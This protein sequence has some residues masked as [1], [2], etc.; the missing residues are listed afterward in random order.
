MCLFLFS[1]SAS[2]EKNADSSVFPVGGLI[3]PDRAWWESNIE[4]YI[5]RKA[6]SKDG[7]DW[8]NIDGKDYTTIPKQ[9]GICGSCAAFAAIGA[10]ESLMKIVHQTPETN[11]D[12]SEQHLF[13]CAGGDCAVG[14][15]LTEVMGLLVNDGTPTEKCYPYT[16]GDTGENVLCSDT[17][18]DWESEAVR[19]KRYTWPETRKDIKAALME[20]P[21]IAAIHMT[22]G[23][24]DY[25]GGIFDGA[26]CGGPDDVNHAVTLV[27]YD[28]DQGYW[29]A[30]NSWSHLWGE[31]GFFRIKFGVCGIESWVLKPV[32]EL[33]Q[34]E[35][36]KDRCKELID[37]IYDECGFSL[38]IESS[39]VDIE[40]AQSECDQSNEIW[41]CMESCLDHENVTNC[42]T[43]GDCLKSKCG[44][45]VL[46]GNSAGSSDED[47]EKEGGCSNS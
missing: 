23:L 22:Q 28:E 46:G 4:R 31:N 6:A 32:Y 26:D 45:V 30:K 34:E 18:E 42:E 43:F 15:E 3:A 14:A 7:I 2:T 41:A 21:I 27:G 35:S 8:R 16:V 25:A 10:L 9:Q 33:E 24:M 17:C 11:Y 19:L 12:L 39:S 20:G 5:P 37:R 40:M 47:D 1:T 13:F 36:P 38:T 29:I 44:V